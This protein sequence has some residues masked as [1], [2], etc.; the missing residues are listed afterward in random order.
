MA[1]CVLT[2]KVFNHEATFL[3]S[4]IVPIQNKIV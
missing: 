1:C 2:I 3:R 4:K